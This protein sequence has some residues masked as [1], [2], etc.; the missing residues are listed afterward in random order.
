M[1]KADVLDLFDSRMRADPPKKEGI[2]RLWFDGILR[3]TGAYNFIGWWN[4]PEGRTSEIVYREAAYFRDRGG[5]EWQVYDHDRPAG[6]EAVLA[7]AGFID[8][9]QETFLVADVAELR[10]AMVPPVGFQISR[11]YD[12]V[13]LADYASASAA[14]FGNGDLAGIEHYRSRLTDPT[15]A[16]YVAYVNGSPVASGRLELPEDRPFAGLWDGGTVSDFRGRGVYRALVAARVA[17]ARSRGARY[18]YVDARETS[19]PIL[20]RLGFEAIATMRGWTLA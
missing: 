9:S 1:N 20:E 2:E 17:E 4:V 8:P 10:L 3:T 11:V 14:A 13:G 15:L 12:D 16:L 5:V 7:D 18:V 19:R 6:L